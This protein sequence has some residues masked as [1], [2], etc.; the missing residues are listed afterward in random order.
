[1]KSREYR[2]IN[3]GLVYWLENG[4]VMVRHPETKKVVVSGYSAETFFIMVG[5]DT[6]ELID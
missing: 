6:L 2:N 5:N 3:N 1:M 4:S